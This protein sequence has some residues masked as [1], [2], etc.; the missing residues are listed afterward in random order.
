MQV[1]E[2][3][4]DRLKNKAEKFKNIAINSFYIPAKKIQ[5]RLTYSDDV[6][7]GNIYFD[8]V[9]KNIVANL[10]FNL[11]NKLKHKYVK[12]VFSKLFIDFVCKEAYGKDVSFRSLEWNN[13][14]KK[15][16]FK[17]DKVSIF[18]KVDDFHYRCECKEY[19]FNIHK[20]FEMTIKKRNCI[21]C[22]TPISFVKEV[23]RKHPIKIS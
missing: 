23:L 12:D 20:H 21:S 22:G 1:N 8:K 5:I 6:A 13:I 18:D 15:F 4:F 2:I 17:N 9:S 11:L 14:A 10:N 16:K 19:H 7:Y 3:Y